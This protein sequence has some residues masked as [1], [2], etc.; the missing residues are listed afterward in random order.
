MTSYGCPNHMLTSMMRVH[1]GRRL[2]K[3]A[4]PLDVVD[5]TSRA[6]CDGGGETQADTSV[7]EDNARSTKETCTHPIT[8]LDLFSGCGGIAHALRQL[9]L[10]IVGLVESNQGCVDTLRLNGFGRI[11]DV[12]PLSFG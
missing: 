3:A 6:G 4:P 2:S 11:I 8:A 7:C 9:G 5:V 1:L 10:E 12:T